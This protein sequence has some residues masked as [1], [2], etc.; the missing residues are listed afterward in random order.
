MRFLKYMAERFHQREGHYPA[1]ILM[2]KFYHKRENRSYCKAHGIRLS[3][4][5]SSGSQNGELWNKVREYWD[6]YQRVG[7]WSRG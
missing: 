3:A 1:R 5:A 7:G 4:P 6:A 2:D